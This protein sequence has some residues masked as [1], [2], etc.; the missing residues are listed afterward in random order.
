MRLRPWPDGATSASLPGMTAPTTTAPR[1]LLVPPNPPH[2]RGGRIARFERG[3]ATCT[4]SPE[5][6]ETKSG[7][8]AQESR[9]IDHLLPTPTPGFG[10]DFT[11]GVLGN[12]ASL[13]PGGSGRPLGQAPEPG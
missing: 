2:A 8:L 13:D 4:P 7:Y 5:K 6:S 10:Q 9:Q 3:R 12:G 1:P 11:G